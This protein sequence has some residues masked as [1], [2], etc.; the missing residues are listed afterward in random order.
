MHA[1]VNDSKENVG[2][3]VHDHLRVFGMSALCSVDKKQ[4][5][6]DFCIDREQ[7]TKL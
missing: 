6:E 1:F 7:W 2:S 5:M 4:R 3:I